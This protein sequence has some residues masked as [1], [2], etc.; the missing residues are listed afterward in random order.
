MAHTLL[1]K[2]V[3]ASSVTRITKNQTSSSQWS[4]HQALVQS[5][6]A[7]CYKLSTHFC[8]LRT[9]MEAIL[10]LLAPKVRDMLR[11]LHIP[12]VEGE[13]MRELTIR[14]GQTSK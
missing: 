3:L 5:T 12:E 2:Q 7:L 10:D 14:L 1:S 6:L 13:A 11:I 8:I 4:S 9:T